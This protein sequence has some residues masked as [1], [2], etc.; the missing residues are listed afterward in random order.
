MTQL[1]TTQHQITH[2]INTII[3]TSNDLRLR[4]DELDNL[5]NQ[6][7]EIPI[8]LT[9]RIKTIVQDDARINLE[10]SHYN[11]LLLAATGV[12]KSKIIIDYIDLFNDAISLKYLRNA[13]VLIVVPTEKLRDINWKEEFIKWTNEHLYNRIRLECYASLNKIENQEFDLVVLDECQNITENNSQFFNQ[14]KVTKII[15]LTATLPPELLKQGILHDLNIKL[16]YQID[17]DTAVKLRLV[18]PFEILVVRVPLDK[19]N[20]IIKAGTKKQPFMTTEYNHYD[21]LTKQMNKVMFISNRTAI[22]E[23]Q[24]QFRIL[25]RMRFIYDLPSKNEAAHWILDHLLNPEDRTIVFCGSI[26]QADELA[27]FTW[28]NENEYQDTH[29]REKGIK[30]KHSFHSK[31]PNDYWYNEFKKGNIKSLCCVNSLNEGHNMG[32]VD[33]ALMVQINSKELKLIQKLGRMIRYRPN[34]RGKAIILIAEGTQDEKWLAKATENIDQS[35]ITYTTFKELKESYESN[36]Q[37]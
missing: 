24:L 9:N 11:P 7:D 37:I 2:Q 32:D 13:K 28:S 18:S 19:T 22:Q 29:I 14:N 35:K 31:S 10:N 16:A 20:R 5:F 30:I 17:L 3:S 1:Q 34:H 23:R 12:G 33:N 6:L 26:K 15:A 25:A 36:I 21:Y 27:N 8:E 4:A